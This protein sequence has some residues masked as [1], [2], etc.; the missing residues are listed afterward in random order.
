MKWFYL[1]AVVL[2]L[3][4]IALGVMFAAGKVSYFLDW[5]SVIMVVF[6]TLVLSLATFP[7]A[8]IG[9]SFAAAFDRRTSTEVELRTA[10]TFFR[11]LQGYLLLSGLLAALLGVMTILAGLKA[12][13]NVA[14]GAALL[15]V[16]VFYSLVLILLVALP[17]RASIE[18]RLAEKS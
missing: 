8:V 11:A 15:L 3:A 13:T 1:V 16:S 5:P 12:D 2:V 7:P 14:G 6:P 18:R 17:F 4:M 10:A 9:R